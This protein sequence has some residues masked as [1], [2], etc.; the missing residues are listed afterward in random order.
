MLLSDDSNHCCIVGAD[1]WFLVVL[2][3]IIGDFFIQTPWLA[4]MR[5]YGIIAGDV[6]ISLNGITHQNNSLVTLEEIDEN[7]A[8]L[9]CL[10]KFTAC[11]R[12]PYSENGSASGN[13]F[14]PNGTRLSSERWDFYRDRQQSM[15]RM[16]RI[17]G[18]VEGIYHC[19]IPDSMNLNQ[20]IYIG[21]YN[22]NSGE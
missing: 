22:T 3:H 9:L 21:V 13:W 7:N 20:N 2:T 14:F 17:R 6:W 4:M 16:N 8:S 11:C 12:P 10:T 5:A 1:K 19:E 15:V 18:G